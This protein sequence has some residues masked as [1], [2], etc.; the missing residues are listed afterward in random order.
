MGAPRE[1]QARVGN[2]HVLPLPS[3]MFAADPFRWGS[4]A[5]EEW[6]K[7]A[8]EDGAAEVWMS[9]TWSALESR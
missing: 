6:F 8:L 1:A 9:S 2:D 5:W 3:R 7:D 4:R